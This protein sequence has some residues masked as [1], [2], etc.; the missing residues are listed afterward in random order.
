[1]KKLHPLRI[2]A[3]HA[4]LC[5]PAFAFAGDVYKCDAGGQAVYQD[6][7]CAGKVVA[8]TRPS[9]FVAGPT[10]PLSSIYR[11]IQS[12]NAESRALDGGHR[13]DLEALRRKLAG[14]TDEQLNRVEI[15]RVHARWLPRIRETNRQ[16]D[17][18]SAELRRR[19]PGGASLNSTH[20]TCSR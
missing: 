7:P 18:L 1:M 20:Q 9:S 4:I 19:C 15:D 6:T 12:L 11:Q 5:T 13:K 16:L 2:A 10:T 8:S 3:I 14:S 17:A